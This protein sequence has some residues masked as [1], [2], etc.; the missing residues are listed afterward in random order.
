MIARDFLVVPAPD[1]NRGHGLLHTLNHV[2]AAMNLT[3]KDVENIAHL[4]RLQ[5]TEEQ[6][7]A[8]A[9]GLSRIMNFVEQLSGADTAQVQPMAHPLS[10]QTQRLRAD[11]VTEK[12]ARARF[13]SNAPQVEAGLYLVPKVI[14]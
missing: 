8:Y 2:R 1:A 13:Q 11:E 5:L 6:L 10:G 3:R 14:E 4:A 9:D 12:D 7:P